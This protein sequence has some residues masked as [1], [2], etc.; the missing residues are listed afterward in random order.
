MSQQ[1]NLDKFDVNGDVREAA[2]KAGVDR[3]TFVRNGMIAGAGAVGVGIFGLP[4]LAQAKISTKRPSVKNDAKI[5]QYALTLEYL[6]A[7]FYAAAVS[8]DNFASPALKQFAQVVA[9]HE[10]QHV[11]DL[12][13]ILGKSAVKAPTLDG[14]AVA[15]LISPENFGPTAALLEDTGVAA[16]AGQGPN[17]KQR[18]VV[19]KALEIHSVEARHAAWIHTLLLPA[20][21]N[22]A[23]AKAL[24]A[25]KAYD[26][27]K[28][29]GSILKAV[30]GLKGGG[31]TLVT[32]ADTSKF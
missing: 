21:V 2:E 29:Q 15:A 7:A 5:L 22:T 3:G 11:K 32:K 30:T 6:E 28:S 17:I 1:Y 19:V 13:A 24:P 16:Y 12:K 4:T 31:K 10:A 20:D 9:K 14:D 27:A 25:P 8:A 23:S 26:K 18:P